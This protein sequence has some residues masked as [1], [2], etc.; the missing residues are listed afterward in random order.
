MTILAILLI[1]AIIYALF[2]KLQVYALSH[3]IVKQECAPPTDEEMRE[4]VTL[5]LKRFFKVS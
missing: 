2:Q 3:W 5:V 1:L 4:S